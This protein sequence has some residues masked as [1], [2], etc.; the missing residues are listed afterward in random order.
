MNAIYQNLHGDL[1]ILR[2]IELKDTDNIIKWRND[3]FIKQN[4]IFREDFTSEMHLHW[5]ETK[6]SSGEVIQYIIEDVS[7][8]RPVG[9]VYYRDI[10]YKNA[11]AEFGIFIG[12]SNARGRGFGA[13]AT[14]LFTEFGFQELKLHRIFL[15]LLSHNKVAYM[16]YQGAGFETEGI[17]RDMVFLDGKYHDIVF[18]SRLANKPVN[19]V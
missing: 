4:F 5:M 18:M 16:S 19:E 7:D 2:P 3:P 6:V 12:E 8:G 11:S 9:S 15:R 17:A 10:D 14:K 13:E 1:V